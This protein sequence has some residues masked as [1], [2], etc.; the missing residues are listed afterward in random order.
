MVF[1]LLFFFIFFPNTQ[2]NLY[3]LRLLRKSSN[4]LGVG[5]LVGQNCREFLVGSGR[6]WMPLPQVGGEERVGF[7]DGVESGLHKVSHGLGATRGSRE[8]IFDSGVLEDL[9]GSLGSDDASSSR[10]W[11]QTDSHRTALAGD[12]C[13]DGVRK[14]DFVTP[15]TTSNGNDR[16]LGGDDGPTNRG[17]DF[18][19]AFDPEADVS[20]RV[21][22]D[23]EGLE[24]GPLTGASL[25]LDGHDLHH[26]VLEGRAE[27]SVDDLVLFDGEGEEVDVFQSLD[28]SFFDE[29]TQLG[30]RGPNFIFL[31]AGSALT[32]SSSSSSAISAS[33]SASSTISAVSATTTSE[34]SSS[35]SFF[36]HGK[37]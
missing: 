5:A 34:S 25:F 26:F 13:W 30:D 17:G 33:T 27:E 29:S 36:R 4:S 21:S 14:T 23:D 35:A 9:L 12:L 16:K 24:S 2:N 37:I 32:T 31:V 19:G 11:H 18:F 8:H 22:D 20:V 7:G 10:R 3:I 6:K 28:E 15:V 1:F